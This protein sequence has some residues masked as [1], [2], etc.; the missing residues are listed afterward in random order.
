MIEKLINGTISERR[1]KWLGGE[2]WT[3]PEVVQLLKRVEGWT[4]NG[5]LFVQS[6][7]KGSKIRVFPRNY[8]TLPNSNENVT[9]YLGFSFDGMEQLLLT[10][11]S[12]NKVHI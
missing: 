9:F 5:H 1:L 8:A 10:S 7:I 11:R 12:R 2:V 6:T 3:N 4:E